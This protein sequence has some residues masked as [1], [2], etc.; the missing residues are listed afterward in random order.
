MESPVLQD[1]IRPFGQTCFGCGQENTHGLRIQSRWEGDEVV[2]RWAP[3]P[4]H[5]AGPGFLNGGV[6]ATIM[7]CHMGVAA[8]ADAY[9]EAGRP[10]GSDP[11]LVYVTATLRVD[12]LKPT[13]VDDPVELRARVT[14]RSGRKH[15]V[16][17]SLHAGGQE[18][19]RAEA[20]F[21]ALPTRETP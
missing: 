17:C 6:I 7:D 2:C 10:L 14:E 11:Q 18:T 8:T 13:P 9:R 16:V 19:A 1:Q 5:V 4:W 12:Y 21:V 3:Q 20:V 15:T